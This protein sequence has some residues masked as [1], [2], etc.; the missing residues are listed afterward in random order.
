MVTVTINMTVDDMEFLKSSLL[1]AEQNTFISDREG[2]ELDKEKVK[3]A[4]TQINHILQ[5]FGW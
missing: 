2:A 1:Q 5:H 3:L 4:N